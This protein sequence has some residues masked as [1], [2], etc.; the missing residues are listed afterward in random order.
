MK[1]QKKKM[2]TDT[3]TQTKQNVQDKENLI[4]LK[5][6]NNEPNKII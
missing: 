6:N 4:K 3:Q 2:K 1:Y 5:D